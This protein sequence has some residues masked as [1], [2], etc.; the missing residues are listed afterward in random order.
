M[1]Y[2][3]GKYF[4]RDAIVLPAGKSV[5][6]YRDLSPRMGLAYDLFGNGKTAVKFN[7]GRYLAEA[8]NSGNYILKNPSAQL[9]NTAY[10]GTGNRGWTDN[11][12]DYAIDCDITN[13]A[14]QGP[15]AGG[16]ADDGRLLRSVDHVL[17]FR[18]H[19]LDLGIDLY[20]FLN[21]DSVTSR[22]VNFN[23]SGVNQANWQ[24]PLE[25]QAARFAKFYLQYDF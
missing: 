18:G 3:P 7:Y 17:R 15:T 11:D 14:A 6:G 1:T 5:T 24:R 22:D 20:N 19:R 9:T 16:G 13:P 12:G 4:V 21:I 10:S 2:G 8:N 23:T 25:V